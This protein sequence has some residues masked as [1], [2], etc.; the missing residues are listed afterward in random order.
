MENTLF[1]YNSG[2]KRVVEK[3]RRLYVV[4]CT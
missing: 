2:A 1:V 3:V 4:L